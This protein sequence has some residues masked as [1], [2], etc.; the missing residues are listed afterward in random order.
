MLF[1]EEPFI[2]RLMFKKIFIWEDK[3]V[4]LPYTAKNIYL[5][6]PQRNKMEKIEIP[7]GKKS[8]NQI[9]M[10]FDEYSLY[11]DCIYMVGCEYPGII[12]V[13]LRSAE[14]SELN[15]IP[16]NLYEKA[17]ERKSYFFGNGVVD[18]NRMYI[19]SRVSNEVFKLDMDNSYIEINKV[20]NVDNTYGGIFQIGTKDYYLV[21]ISNDNLIWWN[22]QNGMYKEYEMHLDQHTPY[23]SLYDGGERIW[24]VLAG[25]VT[26]IYEIKKKNMEVKKI[27]L[28][29]CG[30]SLCIE[31]MRGYKG[32]LI[33]VNDV[34]GL[35]YEIGKEGIVHKLN[36]AIEE[37]EEE[38]V[39]RKAEEKC[40]DNVYLREEGVVT[41]E[42]FLSRMRKTI[43]SENV[44]QNMKRAGGIIYNSCIPV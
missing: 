22:P 27:D 28:T 15:G 26:A 32:R 36:F 21:N 44:A 42:A 24:L 19:T 33:F 1:Q 9:Y 5:Y 11:K 17:R 20:G 4:F 29:V 23:R 2:K 3:F 43:I 38:L 18:E 41:L 31:Y 39:W 12:K 37:P 35:W 6:D 40:F 34:D 7:M 13:N 14:V 25:A 30:K 16:Q 8:E 10:N